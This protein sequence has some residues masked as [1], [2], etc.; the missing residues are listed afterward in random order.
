MYGEQ[1]RSF[2]GAAAG[3]MKFK[4]FFINYRRPGVNP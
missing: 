1:Q 2:S 4:E 3:F